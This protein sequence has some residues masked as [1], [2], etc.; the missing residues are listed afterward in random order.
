MSSP[1]WES[2]ARVEVQSYSSYIIT[3][4]MPI[5]KQNLLLTWPRNTLWGAQQF[6]GNCRWFLF[7]V[8]VWWFADMYKLDS[9]Y[10]HKSF[11]YIATYRKLFWTDWGSQSHIGSSNLDGSDRRVIVSSDLSWPN[12]LVIDFRGKQLHFSVFLQC[13][14]IDHFLVKGRTLHNETFKWPNIVYSY[15]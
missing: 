11:F 6:S 12:G 14:L 2:H 9:N 3:L 1:R 5:W 10:A 13:Y 4:I 15:T 8:F 7:K